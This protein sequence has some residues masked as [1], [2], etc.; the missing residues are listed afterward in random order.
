MREEVPLRALR[1]GHAQILD[2]DARVFGFEFDAE[3]AA[4]KP[5]R[6]VAFGPDA[7]ERA[8]H[9]FAGIRPEPDAPFDR[10]QLQR[11]D[12]ALVVVTVTSTVAAACGGAMAVICV[13][14]SRVNAAATEPKATA[15]APRKNWPVMTTLVPP[16]VLPEV[17]PRL[18]TSGA[19]SA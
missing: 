6:F 7:G 3:V 4:S 11:A 15:V 13:G 17:V 12:V 8:E 18:A 10:A 14:E 1:F 5:D 2:G 9:E 19:T 16:P